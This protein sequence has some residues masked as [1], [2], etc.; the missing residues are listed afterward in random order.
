MHLAVVD[1]EADTTR[2]LLNG[3]AKGWYVPTGHLMYV[4]SD[5]AVF[6]APFDLGSLQLTGPGI[7]L[8]QDVTVIV[9]SVDL[10]VAADG[11]V[12]YRQATSVGADRE[13]VWVD[14]TGEAEPVDPD[15]EPDAFENLALAPDDG[16]VAL[17]GRIAAEGRPQLW[18]KQ[19]PGGPMRRLTRDTS[20]N[21]RPAWSPDGSTVAYI[22]GEGGDHVR[23]VPADGSSAGSFDVLLTHDRG[24]LEVSYAPDGTGLLVRL[25]DTGGNPDIGF[26]DLATDSVREDVLA[27]E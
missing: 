11:T 20:S 16:R 5:G 9:S 15:M 4:R 27:S 12:L 19:L 21:L 3:V 18:V 24:V 14:R 6:A 8:F 17:T 13:L 22:N 23:S 1:F 10:A 7:P 2:V 26:L 25:G